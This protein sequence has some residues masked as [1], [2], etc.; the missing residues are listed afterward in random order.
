MSAEKSIKRWSP[1]W[2]QNT[3]IEDRNTINYLAS[4]PNA[5]K[6]GD[7]K[8]RARAKAIKREQS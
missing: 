2:W 7:P 3:S 4:Q 6:H 8:V 5:E 1:K